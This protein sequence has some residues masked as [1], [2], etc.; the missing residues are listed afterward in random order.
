[1]LRLKV[2]AFS[3]LMMGVISVIL[4]IQRRLPEPVKEL[5]LVKQGT[6]SNPP[7]DLIIRHP[8]S[9]LTIRIRK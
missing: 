9:Y 5:Y 4:S 1:M 8:D 3:A 6:Q 7:L 2:D